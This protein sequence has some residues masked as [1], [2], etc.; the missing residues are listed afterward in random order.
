MNMSNMLIV[1]QSAVLA[2]GLVSGVFLTFS[3]FVMRSLAA[4]EPRGGIEAMQIINRKVF[5]TLFMV[6]LLGLSALSP[7]LAYVAL[8]QM[9]GPAAGY[10]L[11]ASALY[12]TGVFLV[13]MFCNVPMNQRLDG[14]D[15]TS[16]EA[17]EYWGFYARR[18]T[19][20]NHFRAT[21]SA[22][23]A[24]LFLAASMELGAM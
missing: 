13:T 2:C 1:C 22:G 14:M 24:A 20:W 9:S 10:V 19:F 5:A 18:W 17:E 6:L 23:A 21:S 11:A 12:F 15:Y 7:Y 8:T 3:D 16:A 4:T